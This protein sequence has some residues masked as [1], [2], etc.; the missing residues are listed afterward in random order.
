M[1]FC[2]SFSERLRWSDLCGEKVNPYNFPVLKLFYGRHLPGK[3][4]YLPQ[5]RW[6]SESGPVRPSSSLK[7]TIRRRSAKFGRTVLSE[8]LPTV[9]IIV[10][11]VSGN[12]WWPFLKCEKLYCSYGGYFVTYR[13]FSVKSPGRTNGFIRNWKCSPSVNVFILALVCS[14]TKRIVSVNSY[15]VNP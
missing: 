1:C 6:S 13:R 4:S 5:L 9:K 8:H 11:A 12:L 7:G 14:T 2:G 10:E 15:G 3:F